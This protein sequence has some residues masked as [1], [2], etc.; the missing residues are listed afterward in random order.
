MTRRGLVHN[1]WLRIGNGNLKLGAP[2]QRGTK[3]LGP[4]S[5]WQVVLGEELVQK[6]C[7]PKVVTAAR[8]D[9]RLPRHLQM[10]CSQT[11]L[12]PEFVRIPVYHVFLRMNWVLEIHLDHLQRVSKVFCNVSTTIDRHPDNAG[13]TLR[14]CFR[15]PMKVIFESFIHEQL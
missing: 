14:F 11:I 12:V 9:G 10:A 3:K 1:A 7:F 8:V 13:D 15:D 6:V 2:F 5:L 4:F